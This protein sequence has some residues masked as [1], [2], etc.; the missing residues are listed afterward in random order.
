[1]AEFLCATSRFVIDALDGPDAAGRFTQETNIETGHN[2]NRNTFESVHHLF[3]NITNVPTD[4]M[5]LEPVM[6]TRMYPESGIRVKPVRV[7]F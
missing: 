5:L 4:V 7:K 2:P 3:C 1:M 6:G